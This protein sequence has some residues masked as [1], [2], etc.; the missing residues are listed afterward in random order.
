MQYDGE[1]TLEIDDA[2][3]AIPQQIRQALFAHWSMGTA[4]GSNT[5]AVGADWITD[6]N[7]NPARLGTGANARVVPLEMN[8]FLHPSSFEAWK[9]FKSTP[10][11]VI[12]AYL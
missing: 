7:A 4:A 9:K 1:I 5:N 6:A 12:S 10:G 2:T 8:D 3:N 11:A